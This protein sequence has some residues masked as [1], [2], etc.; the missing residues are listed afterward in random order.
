MKKMFVAIIVCVMVMVP[1]VVLAEKS[2]EMLKM[3]RNV[4]NERVFR[5]TAESNLLK[6]QSA[7]AV[8]VKAEADRL[9]AEISKAIPVVQESI[10]QYNEQITAMEAAAKVPTEPVKEDTKD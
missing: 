10:K 1:S 5:L 4:L 9:I 8:R 6:M 3:E 7:E 2:L